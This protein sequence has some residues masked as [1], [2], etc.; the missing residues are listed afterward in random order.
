MPTRRTV[1]TSLTDTRNR[2]VRSWS[3]QPSRSRWSPLRSQSPARRARRTCAVG[4]A[5][6]RAATPKPYVLEGGE[7][8]P[9]YSYKNAIRESVWVQAPDG[10]GDGKPDL[11]TADI[12]RPKELDGKTKVPGDH[13]RQPV[14]PV[15]R[16]RQRVRDEDL[17]RERA[18]AQAPALLRQLLRAA[19]LRH[20]R[21]RHGGHGP[22]HGCADEGAASDID[23][24]KAVIDWLNGRAKAVDI[25]GKPVKANWATAKSGMIGKSYDGTLANG[26]AA[27]GVKGLKTIVPIS[28]ISS[29]YDYDRSQGVPFS[30]NYPAGL[31]ELVESNRTRQVD[32]S[33]V[34][35]EMNQRRR[36]RDR[37]LHEVLVGPRLPRVAAAVSRPRSRPAS[38]SRH[39]MQDTNVKTVNFGRWYDLMKRT[40][41]PRRS[42]SPGSVTSTRST[43]A[44]RSSGWTP[45]TGGS[46]TS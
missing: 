8:K 2:C 44:G 11:V 36:R 16:A 15:L 4:H 33:A 6:A 10:D 46:T 20:G 35:A 13:G 30:Y 25:N 43:T 31:S 23:S 39:G 19:R 41:S 42:G 26:V 9:V 34:N 40:T 14:L 37:R 27:T 5:A 17:R 22:L 24:V 3:G 28:A 7:S 38:S 29:W 45:C 12:I 18:P 32:C 1:A 21:G